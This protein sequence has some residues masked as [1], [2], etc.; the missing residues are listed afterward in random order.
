MISPVIRHTAE[1]LPVNRLV[2]LAQIPR[3]T[4]YRILYHVPAA[5]LSDLLT[6]EVHRICEQFPRYCYRRVAYELR[7]RGYC[8]NHKRILA[9]MRQQKLLSPPKKRFVRTNDSCHGLSIYPNL[10]ST[11]TTTRPNQVWVADI[12]YIR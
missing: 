5:E 6:K 7:R 4:Y 12:T 2:Q 3:S 10:I 11:M 9:L 8:A 1:S